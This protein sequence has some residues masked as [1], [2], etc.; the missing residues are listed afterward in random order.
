MVDKADAGPELEWLA[1]EYDTLRQESLGSMGHMLQVISL[2][3]AAFGFLSG[4][5][6]FAAKE[7]PIMA[8]VILGIGIPLLVVFTLFIWLGEMNRMVRAGTYIARIERVVNEKL[9]KRTI[10]WET[11]LRQENQM[12]YPY[13][14]TV[15]LFVVAAMPFP[16]VALNLTAL[17]WYPWGGLVLVPL[18]WLLGARWRSRVFLVRLAEWSKKPLQLPGE[19]EPAAG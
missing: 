18:A 2:G 11:W 16:F 15:D 19:E 17:P 12:R 4:A 5:A 6:S 8:A 3:L 10:W 14:R 9:E 7:A 1:R 13:Q